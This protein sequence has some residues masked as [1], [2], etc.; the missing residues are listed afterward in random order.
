M[1]VDMV[2]QRQYVFIVIIVVANSSFM[3]NVN[4]LEEGIG[5]PMDSHIKQTFCNLNK[6]RKKFH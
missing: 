3:F 1:F 2:R 5:Q 6:K 4:E